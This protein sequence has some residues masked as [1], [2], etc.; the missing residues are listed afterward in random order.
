MTTTFIVYGVSFLILLVSL[1]FLY[2]YYKSSWYKS[3]TKLTSSKKKA[4]S[5]ILLGLKGAG[6]SAIFFHLRYGKLVETVSSM[7]ENVHED[8]IDVPGCEITRMDQ[9]LPLAKAIV[10]VIDSV[11]G[12]FKKVAESV[13]SLLALCKPG[14]PIAFICSKQDLP[15]CLD[16]KSVK[17]KLETEL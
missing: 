5:V 16:P 1:A 3:D 15:N 8:L 7:T 9:Y 10:F 14:T 13:Y 2:F 6:K 11:V 12:D 4:S 17:Q